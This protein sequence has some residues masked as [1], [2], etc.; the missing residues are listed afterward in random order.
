M[1]EIIDSTSGEVLARAVDRRAAQPASRTGVRS[2]TVSST[3]EVRRLARR[4]ATQLRDGLDSF[5][6]R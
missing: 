4:W 1:L 3:A 2:S 6:E 5:H